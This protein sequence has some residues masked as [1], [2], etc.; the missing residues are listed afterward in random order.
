MKNKKD[1]VTMELFGKIAVLIEAGRSKVAYAVNLTMVHTYFEIGRMIVENEQQGKKRAEYGKAVLKELS[2]K[3]TEMF[4]KGF[5]VDNLERMKKLYLLYS[6]K[7]S[8]TL[9]RNSSLS[10]SHYL[11]LM[12]IE[13]TEERKFYEIEAVQN[14]WSLSE[15]KRQINSALYERL[16][17][18]RDK[19]KEAFERGEGLT[20]KKQ[21]SDKVHA[22]GRISK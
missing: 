10:W 8:A 13:R 22:G 15:F 7:N 21:G 16:A 4:G 11:V 12:G 6:D 19:K 18:S 20:G 2:G 17:L 9:L 3:L 5:S 1:M 14:Q